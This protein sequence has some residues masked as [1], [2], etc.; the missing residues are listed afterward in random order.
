MNQTNRTDYEL[1]Y[2]ANDYCDVA[3]A[4]ALPWAM[5]IPPLTTTGQGRPLALPQV[6]DHTTL[7]PALATRLAARAGAF[8]ATP[9]TRVLGYA[10]SST[11]DP[12]PSTST[13][14]AMPVAC[15]CDCAAAQVDTD[16]DGIPDTWEIAN[17]LNPNDPQRRPTNRTFDG[18]SGHSRLCPIWRCICTSAANSWWGSRLLRPIGSTENLH[19]VQA[20]PGFALGL[21]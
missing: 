8:R 5:A 10:G 14:Q 15:L 18:G 2:N 13:L 17:H 4:N 7:G 19:T 16:R 3:A 9:W 1:I 12:A 20:T 6:V 11:F 21:V